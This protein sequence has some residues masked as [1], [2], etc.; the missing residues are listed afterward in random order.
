[1]S[2][3]KVVRVV[4]RDEVIATCNGHLARLEQA[5]ARW[6]RD[7][8]RLKAMTPQIAAATQARATAL[9]ALLAQDAFLDLQK[10]VPNEIAFLQSQIQAWEQQVVDNA[11][12]AR[13]R[14]RALRHIAAGLLADI[15]GKDGVVDDSLRAQI[16]TVRDGRAGE[17][18][19]GILARAFNALSAVGTDDT[20]SE[21]Q[22]QLAERLNEGSD[23]PSLAAQLA[24][25]GRGD[26]RE[27][28]FE[29]IDRHIAELDVLGAADDA[30][31]FKRRL[32]T[33]ERDDAN[34]TRNLLLDSLV[35]DLANAVTRYRERLA[36]FERLDEV[37][38]R[39]R[40]IGGQPAD[41]IAAQIA[42]AQSQTDPVAANA[43]IDRWQAL[44]AAHDKRGAGEAR[45][46]AV[47]EGL[48]S[49]GYEVREGMST[50]TPA[51]NT[52]IVRRPSTPGYGVELGG[53]AENGRLQVRVVAFSDT[54]DT[55]RDRDVET[56]W[57]DEVQRL[58][59][60]LAAQG[61]EL[62]IKRSL[63]VG[64]VPLKVIDLGDAEPATDGIRQPN[65][66]QR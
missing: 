36:V 11:A 59:A 61:D 5:I 54:R 27:P 60:L 23:S 25:L 48:A 20:V 22:R 51:N 53:D 42:T 56:L 13:G 40:Q 24:L 46:Q 26:V 15:E 39:L 16:A 35:L 30:I 21:A 57:C 65:T 50:L 12:Q 8:T 2:G 62:A 17:A 3:P 63:P 1:M 58:Q 19:E 28:R 31:E 47:L 52:V 37:A 18:A 38:S 33:I 29:R 4:T 49:L 43:L 55:S 34:P 66:K 14:Q 41:E 6:Q 45:R 9:R 64:A 7:G 44:I 32:E 10:A